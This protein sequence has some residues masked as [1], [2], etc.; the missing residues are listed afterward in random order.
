MLRIGLTGGIGSGKSTVARIFSVLGIPVYDSDTASKRLMAEDEMLKD[1]IIQSF[2]KES[3]TNGRL[4][5]KYLSE[6]VFSDP[7]KTDL[8]NSIVHP[9][10][11]KDAEEWMKK[12]NSPYLIK[13]AALIFESGSNRFL[14]K[15]I[16]VSSPLSLRMERTMKRS[17]ISAEQVKARINLQM[18]EEEKM[19]LCDYI[20][21]NDEQQMLIPQVLLLHKKFLSLT[22]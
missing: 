4:N 5:R 16:G 11:I 18:D 21:V 7:K 10:T 19:A 22:K 1:K 3:Y 9:A 6:Q 15:V 17:N 20:I 12:Q 14:D 8:L 13:E 2:G